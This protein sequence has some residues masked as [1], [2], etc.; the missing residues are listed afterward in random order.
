M[1]RQRNMVQMEEQVENSQDQI[2]KDEIGKL[3][4]KEL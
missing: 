4:V 2:N 1:K 3:L